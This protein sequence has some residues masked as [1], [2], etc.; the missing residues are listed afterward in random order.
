M[1]HEPVVSRARR[2]RL[3]TSS[4]P[5]TRV[6]IIS[7]GV[8][9][10]ELAESI[11]DTHAAE[12]QTY[13]RHS[14]LGRS[15]GCMSPEAIEP[16]CYIERTPYMP[17][18]ITAFSSL[19]ITGKV[20]V[21]TGAARGI[22]HACAQLL[23]TRGA[24]V[25]LSDRSESVREQEADDVAAFVGDTSVDDFSHIGG[26]RALQDLSR[27]AIVIA[28]IRQQVVPGRE[29]PCDRRLATGRRHPALGHAHR[30]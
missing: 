20:A 10:S 16:R 9:E 12:L 28:P 23:Q 18:S 25:V 27:I 19:D 14:I 17:T 3:T 13:R 5:G 30:R 11:T 22:G 7:P 1:T 15:P 8:V 2:Y 6:I 21:V 29:P 4:D 26:S 24:K